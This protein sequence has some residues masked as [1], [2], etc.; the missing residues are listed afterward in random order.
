MNSSTT[1]LPPLV[2]GKNRFTLKSLKEQVNAWSRRPGNAAK[3]W[4]PRIKKK[5]SK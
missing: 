3:S 4:Q 2:G 5:A 1:D